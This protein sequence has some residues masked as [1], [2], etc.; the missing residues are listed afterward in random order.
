MLKVIQH[1]GKH[2]TCHLQGEHILATQPIH[3]HPKDGKCNVC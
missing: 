3:I 2:C 1:F